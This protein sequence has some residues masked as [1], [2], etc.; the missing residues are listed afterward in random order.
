MPFGKC[1]ADFVEQKSREHKRDA[2]PERK[3]CQKKR[4]LSHRCRTGCQKQNTPE[5]RPDTR[6]P[7]N[8]KQCADKQRAFE[9]AD[10]QKVRQC[11]AALGLERWNAHD[12]KHRESKKNDEYACN[13]AEGVAPR[14]Q[15]APDSS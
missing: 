2:E 11:K 6:A 10:R 3:Y 4:T 8:R 15:E 14:T 12:A 5:Y 7:A 1:V 9:P 13:A